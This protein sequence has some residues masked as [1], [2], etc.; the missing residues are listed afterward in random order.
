LLLPGFLP[1]AALGLAGALIR[2]RGRQPA[3]AVILAPLLWAY[4]VALAC[5][6]LSL[7]QALTFAA[8]LAGWSLALVILILALMRSQPAGGFPS[9][10][11]SAVRPGGRH[12][13][14]ARNRDPVRPELRS[15][16]EAAARYVAQQGDRRIGLLTAGNDWEYPLWRLLREEGVKDFRIEHVGVGNAPPAKPYPFG[17]FDPSLVVATIGDPPPRL[18]IDGVSWQRVLQ[19]PHL[20]IY[21]RGP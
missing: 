3:E 10:A 4:G 21:R 15:S 13:G 19:Y 8:L 6:A 20:A 5:E 16:Y 17:P 18:T 1:L 2:R 7:F 12:L 9:A 11:V 14:Q